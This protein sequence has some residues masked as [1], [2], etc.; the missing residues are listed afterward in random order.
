VCW[1]TVTRPAFCPRLCRIPGKQEWKRQLGWESDG[2][3][4]VSLHEGFNLQVFKQCLLDIRDELT[5]G[6]K[7]VETAFQMLDL[8][9]CVGCEGKVGVM[10]FEDNILP[11]KQ[12]MGSIR[13][14]VGMGWSKPKKKSFRGKKTQPGL[15]GP[16]PSKE[17]GQFPQSPSPT[18]PFHYC[19]LS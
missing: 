11:N 16:K 1:A 9:E 7:R 3:G 15:L 5:L 2:N 12:H 10:G 18:G 8:K 19:I 13:S 4:H 6:L 14:N 17:S